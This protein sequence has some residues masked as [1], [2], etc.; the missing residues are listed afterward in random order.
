MEDEI[1]THTVDTITDPDSKRSERSLII[2]VL[3]AAD[4]LDYEEPLSELIENFNHGFNLTIDPVG[5]VVQ[6]V[7]AL[8]E[9]RESLDRLIAPYLEH[10]RYD[11]VTI[12]IRLILR[13]AAWEL[14]HKTVD[15]RIIINEAIELAK[16]YSE[17]E[18]YRLVNGVLDALVKKL[19]A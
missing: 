10:W 4:A 19:Q 6:I 3:Y 12:M 17:P 1:P 14:V 16:E 5:K 18:S 9:E 8:I 13:Y 15:P 2:N 11:R 7:R